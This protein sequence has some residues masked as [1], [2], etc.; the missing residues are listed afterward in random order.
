MQGSV[1]VL[2]QML[3][4]YVRAQQHTVDFAAIYKSKTE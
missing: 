3:E 1:Q 2:P 4:H